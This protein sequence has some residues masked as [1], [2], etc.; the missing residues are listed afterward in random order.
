MRIRCVCNVFFTVINLNRRQKEEDEKEISPLRWFIIFFQN[1]FALVLAFLIGSLL[2]LMIGDYFTW[3][4][5]YKSRL[6]MKIE[7]LERFIEQHDH[8]KANERNGWRP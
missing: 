8:D 6:E 5:G 2:G 3:R 4:H 1:F 7:R